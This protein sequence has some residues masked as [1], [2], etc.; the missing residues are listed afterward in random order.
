M[1]HF[2][3]IKYFFT[4]FTLAT[5][6][7]S[8][9]KFIEVDLPTD[10]LTTQ[11]VFSNDES[12]LAAIRGLYSEI[13]KNNVYIGHGAMSV[14]PALSADELNTNSGDPTE[15]AYVNN[16]IPVNSFPLLTNIWQKGYF[17]IYQANAI[18]ENLSI[19]N[20]ISPAVKD[21]ISGEA[22]FFRA[23]FHFYLVNLFGPVPLAMT[24]DYRN[25]AI[26]ARSD[27]AIVYQQIVADLLDAQKLVSTNYPTPEKVRVNKWAVTAF[28]ARVYLY[29]KDWTQAEIEV[30][31]VINSSA[32]KLSTLNNTFLP[33]SSETILQFLPPITQ[34]WNTSE[35][36]SFLPFSSLASPSY[37]LTNSLMGSFEPGDERKTNWVNSMAVNNITYY[38]PFKFKVKSVT[39][40]APKTEYSVVLRLGEQY[41]I[42][43]EAR[44]N[45][46][47]LGG[48]QSDLNLIRSRAGLSNTTANDKVNLLLAIQKERQIELLCEWGH[49]WF[50]L[51]RTGRIDNILS[52]IKGSNWQPTDALYPIPQN[53]M[54]T[55]SSLTQNPGY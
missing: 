47:N 41:L 37:S 29:L 23:F 36:F 25:N 53:E 18:L 24:T 9:E 19:S 17:H 10:Q 6:L 27:T 39:A 8:C 31:N 22:K 12:A 5:G 13:T 28:L 15:I 45:L 49:R 4:V 11:S 3:Y 55:N 44:A 7:F 35:G 34:I 26:I 16:A 14:Y 20:D 33:T 43:A 40:G 30:S 32:Y 46:N 54:L 50:D 21:Q 51:K 52:A 38:Y 1:K 2:N 48:A 42:R